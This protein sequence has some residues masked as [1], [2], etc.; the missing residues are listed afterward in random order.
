MSVLVSPVRKQKP[1][2]II[3]VAGQQTYKRTD[4]TANLKAYACSVNKSIFL[5]KNHSQFMGSCFVYSC[6]GKKDGGLCCFEVI[7]KRKIVKKEELY[8]ISKVNLS[9]DA[10]MR[11]S[12][13]PSLKQ[14]LDD[15]DIVEIA[16]TSLGLR[17]LKAVALTVS[18]MRMTNKM[19]SRLHVNTKNEVSIMITYHY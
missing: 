2:I 1:A 3:P 14:M 17:Q 16:K 12:A 8:I 10:C 5:D 9:H 13:S 11:G 15:P 4:L 19:A 7:A 18:N 6:L